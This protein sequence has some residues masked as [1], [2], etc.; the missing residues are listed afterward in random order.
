MA[1][2]EWFEMVY[3]CPVHDQFEIGIFKSCWVAVY[4]GEL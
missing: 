4:I 1:T 3:Y 2:G